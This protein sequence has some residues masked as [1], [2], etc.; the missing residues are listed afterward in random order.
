M[1]LGRG[2]YI[3]NEGSKKEGRCMTIVFKS[4]RRRGKEKSNGTVHGASNNERYTR[5]NK[6]VTEP[7][8]KGGGGRKIREE[9]KCSPPQEVTR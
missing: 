3:I 7:H 4:K 8:F 6:T 2:E 9:R 1:N 5:S